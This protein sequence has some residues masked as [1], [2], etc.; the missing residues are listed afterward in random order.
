M[1][2]FDFRLQ[3]VIEVREVKKKECERKL[4]QS[5]EGLREEERQLREAA[6]QSQASH[7]GL[8]QALK[9]RSNAGMLA[10]LDGWRRHQEKELHLQALKTAEQEQEVDRQRSALIQAAK[11]KKVLDRLREKKLDEYHSE[12]AQEEQKFLDE[13]GCR[14]GRSWISEFK[15]DKGA[16]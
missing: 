6:D 16:K 3:R 15:F 8:R 4:A 14:I 12:C 2:K 13:L 10:S 5:V 11:E 1:K 7:E 9:N